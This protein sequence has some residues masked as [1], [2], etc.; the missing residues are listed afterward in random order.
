[1][2]DRAALPLAERIRRAT[3][4]T[5]PKNMFTRFT[6]RARRVIVLA[7]DEARERGHGFVGPEHLLL[8]LL[9]EGEDVADLALESLG[10]SLEEAR[11]PGRG[12]RRPWPGHARGP[13]SVHAADQAGAGAVAAGGAAAR[14]PV[15]RH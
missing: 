4:R 3:I 7:Q 15:R 8:G 13:R 5:R 6:A 10:I 1:M 12:D 11:E 14:A 2:R 9:A